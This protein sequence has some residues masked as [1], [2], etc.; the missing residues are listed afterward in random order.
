[1]RSVG[2]HPFRAEQRPAHG[3]QHSRTLPKAAYEV[4]GFEAGM[5]RGQGSACMMPVHTWLPQWARFTSVQQQQLL[6]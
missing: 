3:G 5:G 1:M 6:P 2:A 4:F